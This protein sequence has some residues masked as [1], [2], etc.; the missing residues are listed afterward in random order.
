MSDFQ[1]LID[2]P[3]LSPQ[4]IAKKYGLHASKVRRIFVDEPGVIRIGHSATRQKKQYFT[5]RIPLS[6]VLRVFDRMTVGGEEG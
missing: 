3:K 1:T 6:V 4:E 5:L 2:E